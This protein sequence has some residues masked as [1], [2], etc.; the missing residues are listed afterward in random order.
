[1]TIRTRLTL[2]YAG[3]QCASILV[4][5]AVAYHEFVVEKNH[6]IRTALRQAGQPDLEGPEEESEELRDIFLGYVLPAAVLAVGGGWFLTRR[7]LAPV[8]ALTA[9]VERI[10]DRTLGEALPRTGNGDELDRLTEVFNAM[11]ARLDGSFQRIRDFTLHASH[12]L[13]TPL[14][15]LHGELEAALEDPAL[16]PAHRERCQTQLDEVQRLAKIA[17]GLTLLTRAD[18]GQVPLAREPVQLDDLVRDAL[19]DA[20]I[21][22]R[23]NGVQ[24]N[25]GACEKLVVTGNR[26]RLRQ[27]LLNLTDNAIKY[28]E[29]G[30]S[31]TLTLKRIGE[32]AELTVANTGP[33]IPPEKIARVFDRFFRVDDSHN[34]AVEG[35]GLGL[36]IVQWIVAAHGGSIRVTSLPESLTTVTVRLPIVTVV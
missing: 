18:A 14:T 6:R 3:V 30:G 8:A 33:G 34:N 20:L 36:S 35:C 29:P 31:V 9:A 22:A 5:G 28:N 21:L 32:E 13:K 4:I 17:D 11:T 15:V 23:P 25:L 2:W 16:P 7:A 27:L 1:V 26:H 10:D 24:V 12:E 19:D